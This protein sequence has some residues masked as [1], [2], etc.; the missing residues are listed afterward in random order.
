YSFND[1]YLATVNFRADG[2]SKFPEKAWGY[3]PSFALAWRMN[4][5]SFLRDVT[6]LSNLKLRFGWGKVGNDN[7]NNNA[8]LLTMFNTGP[9]FVDYVF[10]ADQQL[11]SGATV[12]TWINNGGHWENTA[13]WS[14]GVDFGFFNNRLN[15]SIDAFIRDTQDMLMSV[16]APAHVGNR[17]SAMANVGE[18]RNKG[19]E[20]SLNYD[21]SIGRDFH[22]SIGGNVS[23]IDN[24]LTHLNGGSVIRSNYDGVQVVDEGHSLN[25]FWGYRYEGVYRSDEEVLEHLSGY[26]AAN[27]PF[28]AGDARYADIN[29]DG[30]IDSNDRVDLGNSIP[31]LN[32]GINLAAYWKDFDLQLFFQG[33]GGNKIYNQKRMQ[34]ESN[35]SSSVLSPVMAD[36]WTVDNPDGSLPNAVNSVNYYT[37][38]RFLESGS[39]FRLKNLQLGY[40]LPRNLIGKAGFQNCRLYLQGGN[41]FTVTKYTGFDP[42]VSGGVDYGNYPQSRTFIFGINITY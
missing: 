33:V 19:I 6:W 34:L 37:S 2:S 18:V 38:D 35:G 22:Y 28:H 40:S 27:T 7:I 15:G 41:L 1:R 30:I 4:Q 31:W 12:L 29:N 36:V 20:I 13:Q 26:N 32:Y 25:Y 23:F 9:T 24:K 11:A 5:E 17:Y 10:G 16:N 21:N 8:F 39:Y 14:A 3:F 42:E